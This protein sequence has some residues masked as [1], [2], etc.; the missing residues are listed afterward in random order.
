MK[1]KPANAAARRSHR[2]VELLA[3]RYFDGMSN[4]ELAEALSTSAVNVSRDM[5]TLE[6]LGYA[7]KLDSGRWSLSSRPLAVMQ[8]YYAHYQQLHERMAET[9]RNIVAAAGRYT[10]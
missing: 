5:A 10:P 6:E 9:T 8:A 7:R 4:R 3:S 2:I 1:E